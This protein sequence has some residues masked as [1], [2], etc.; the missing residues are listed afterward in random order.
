MGRFRDSDQR[1]LSRA[2]TRAQHHFCYTALAFR[3]VDAKGS[4]QSKDTTCESIAIRQAKDD[5]A[6]NQDRS[7]WGRGLD[8]SPVSGLKRQDLR[9][10]TEHDRGAKDNYGVSDLGD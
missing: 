9:P 1:L 3:K 4:R 5:E 2:A 6:S 8:V 10:K 7:R